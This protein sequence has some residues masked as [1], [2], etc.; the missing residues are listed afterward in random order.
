[1]VQLGLYA[2]MQIPAGAMA[3][4]FGP[5]RMLLAAVALMGAGELAF[6]LT[7][8]A[9]V[10][11]LGRA[12]VG[13]GDAV[14]FLSVLRLAQNWFPV[15]RYGLLASLTG[16]VGGV[17][18]IVSTVPLHVGLTRLG[19][20]TTFAT[21]AL[22]TL[23]IGALVWL[24]LSDRPEAPKIAA[25]TPARR[26]PLPPRQPGDRMVDAVRQVM[27]QR[28]TWRGTWAHFALSGPFA[29]FTALWGYPFLVRAEHLHPARASDALALVVVAA[30]A[31][32]PPVGLLMVRAPGRRVAFVYATGG[33]LAGVWVLNLVL[34]LGHDPG[35]L[36]V[37]LLVATGVAGPA[38]VVA[39]DLARQANPAERGGAATG[40]VNI[41]GFTAAVL[42]DLAIGALL[43]TVGHGGHSPAGFTAAMAVMPAMVAVG[44]LGFWWSGRT[45]LARRPPVG[46]T[47]V[48]R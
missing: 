45:P 43:D 23:A 24:V 33:L 19:W 2:L 44:L 4:R 38:S 3:D 40:V 39:F 12:L 22:A 46:E 13:L 25:T 29:V 48:L 21:S 18:G 31:G 14:T 36:I 9:G 47:P 7:H 8:S 16:L 1:A 15:T 6:A 5:K 10:A 35:W 37:V 20:T 32:A 42:A 26:A 11:L 41:G 27:G 34:G 17:G 30:V 28:G